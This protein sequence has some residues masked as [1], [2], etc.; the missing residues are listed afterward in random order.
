M[1]HSDFWGL[2]NQ[3]CC[4]YLALK[5]MPPYRVPLKAIL[6]KNGLILEKEGPL[7]LFFMIY[8]LLKLGKIAKERPENMWGKKRPHIWGGGEFYNCNQQWMHCREW[9]KVFKYLH[10]QNV[11]KVQYI[12]T[13]QYYRIHSSVT[14]FP[15]V[16]CFD[17]LIWNQPNR[18]FWY[19]FYFRLL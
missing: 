5:R 18:V 11:M 1:Q 15:S 2:L 14:Q 4:S 9:K 3:Y 8:Y 10:I 6:S 13:I 17:N 19:R 7:G 12:F 16:L